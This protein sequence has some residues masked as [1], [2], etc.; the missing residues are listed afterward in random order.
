MLNTRL[1]T[2]VDRL[3]ADG[4][5]AVTQYIADIEAGRLP[6]ALQNLEPEEQQA[7][8]AEIKSVMAVYEQR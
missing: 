3:C 8:L 6:P 7:V 1:Q 4:C 5:Q 2:I